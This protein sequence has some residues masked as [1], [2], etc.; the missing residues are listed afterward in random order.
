MECVLHVFY[1]I[2]RIPSTIIN[3][4]TPFELLFKYVPTYTH[5]KIFVCLRF[6]S[7][8]SLNRSK[9]DSKALKC[10]FLE[11]PSHIKEYKVLYLQFQKLYI[12]RDIDFVETQSPF[13]ST[14]QKSSNTLVLP[15]IT[16]CSDENWYVEHQDVASHE[17]SPVPI[18]SGNTSY[19]SPIIA[20][21]NTSLDISISNN[22][23]VHVPQKSTR[24][25]K[26]SSHLN[27][28]YLSGFKSPFNSNVSTPH[29]IYHFV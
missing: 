21:D 19:F 14:S 2:N 28:Y 11:Y 16:Y 12:S 9:F 23:H 10:V 7:N 20:Y 27:D 25:R 13:M 17:E 18:N 26:Q 3:N 6:V 24:L 15:H 1:L 29:C 5:L 22:E 8:L 4:K